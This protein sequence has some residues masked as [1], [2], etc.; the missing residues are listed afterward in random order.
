M[1][2]NYV[3]TTFASMSP[4]PPDKPSHIPWAGDLFEL[5]KGYLGYKSAKL[6]VKAAKKINIVQDK[7]SSSPPPSGPDGG[8]DLRKAAPVLAIGGGVLVLVLM[9][10]G[11]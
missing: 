6:E 10:R 3:P 11:R 9:M 5:A 2:I 1:T 8:F 4:T 7:G